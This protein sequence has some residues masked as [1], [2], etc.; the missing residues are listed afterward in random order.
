MPGRGHGTRAWAG[1]SPG[2]QTASG[3]CRYACR[4]FRLNR[5]GIE[6][7]CPVRLLCRDTFFGCLLPRLRPPVEGG[8]IF[9]QNG[10][11]ANCNR[12][13]L[14]RSPGTVHREQPSR[15][16]ASV[17]PGGR[18]RAGT[19]AGKSE[20]ELS[21]RGHPGRRTSSP[22]VSVSVTA[23]AMMMLASRSWRPSS[24]PPRHRLSRIR[25]RTE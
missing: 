23:W 16:M 6:A 14:C 19:T 22:T 9:A 4:H 10:A 18:C 20:P 7:V 1:C 11:F 5:V 12:T 2:S 24:N 3:K 17:C 15:G 25:A 8:L 13:I 21:Q